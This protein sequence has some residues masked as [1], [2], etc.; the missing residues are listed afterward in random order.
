MDNNNSKVDVRPS[1]KRRRSAASS[2][3]SFCFSGCFSKHKTSKSNANAN[4]GIEGEDHQHRHRHHRD[5]QPQPR[6]RRTSSTWLKAR[7]SDFP[8]LRDRYRNIISNLGR[9]QR[10]HASDFSYDAFSYALNFDDE[11]R[12]D[13]VFPPRSFSARLPPT[14][15]PPTEEAATDA[16]VDAI[17]VISS[18]RT[19]G[20]VNV[21]KFQIS[22]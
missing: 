2:S 4:D 3:S 10:R 15:Q 21:F 11:S 16:P 18:P 19:I 12:V 14:P 5:H 9:T 17:G 6:L 20:E 22:D 7:M 8:E 13:D 1:H